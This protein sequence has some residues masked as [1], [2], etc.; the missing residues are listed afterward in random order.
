VKFVPEAAKEYDALPDRERAAIQEAIQ[1]LKVLGDQLGAPHSSK[2][3]GIQGT[4]R[5]LRPRRGSSPIRAFYRRIGDFMVIGAVGPEAEVDQRG[6]RRAVAHAISRLDE[7]RSD[8][9]RD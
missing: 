8:E 2:V 7:F 6:F 1:K 3:L 5:E 9:E 4:L